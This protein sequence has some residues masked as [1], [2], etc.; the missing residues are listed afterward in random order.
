M[1]LALFYHLTRSPVEV[2]VAQLLERAVATG[3][4]VELR[5]TRADRMDWLDE[6][7]W[8]G[9]DA[10]FVGHGRAG[11]AHDALQ[12]VLLTTV[13]DGAGVAAAAGRRALMTLDGAQVD[14]AECAVLERVW[15]LFDGT[16]PAALEI[17]RVQWRVL[18]AAALPAQ[19]W[20]EESG[21]WEKKAER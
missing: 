14:P 17:A 10:G 4:R 5:G 8:L 15:V 9:P 2:L 21:R 19:Y 11:G 13:G 6:R 18:T 1:A 20:S 3:W 7:L 16:D 12:P